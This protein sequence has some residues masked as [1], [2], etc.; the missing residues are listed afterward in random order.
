MSR[1]GSK[2]AVLTRNGL[3]AFL[4]KRRPEKNLHYSLT[5]TGLRLKSLQTDVVQFEQEQI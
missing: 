3:G 4:P 2:N 1:V 5:R